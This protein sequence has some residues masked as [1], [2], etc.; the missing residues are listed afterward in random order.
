MDLTSTLK[1]P[2]SSNCVDIWSEGLPTAW[3]TW[4]FAIT[5]C[6]CFEDEI[7]DATSLCISVKCGCPYS[8][9]KMQLKV[10]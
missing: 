10:I 3:L 2:I 9:I 1:I 6:K 7:D 4:P 5:V 8:V